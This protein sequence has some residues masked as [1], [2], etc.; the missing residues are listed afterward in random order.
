MEDTNI[1]L[2]DNLDLTL[3][4]MNFSLNLDLEKFKAEY[5]IL[6]LTQNKFKIQ[7]VSK[8]EGYLF[9]G[10]HF[11]QTHFKAIEIILDL[12]I[13]NYPGKF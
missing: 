8:H 13:G 11:V 9:E 5:N 12:D 3:F 6:C 1:F 7:E 2:L 4:F 10:W